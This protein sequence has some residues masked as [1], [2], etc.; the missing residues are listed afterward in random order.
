LIPFN[1]DNFYT[2]VP[3]LRDD[4]LKHMGQYSEKTLMERYYEAIGK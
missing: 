3:I 1:Y 2:T 4:D